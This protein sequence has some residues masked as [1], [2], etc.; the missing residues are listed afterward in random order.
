MPRPWRL[1]WRRGRGAAAARRLPSRRRAAPGVLAQLSPDAFATATAAKIEGALHLDRLTRA[2]PLEH[3]V[4]F[5][6]AAALLGLP[7]QGA[8]AAAN[9]A[10]DALARRRRAAGLPALSIGWGRWSEVGMVASDAVRLEAAGHGAIVPDAGLAL[11]ERI[12]D[13]PA[14]QAVLPADWPRLLAGLPRRPT[15]LAELERPAPQPV[16]QPAPPAPAVPAGPAPGGMMGYLVA[17]LQRITGAAMP[18]PAT[19]TLLELGL[20]S[21]TSINLRNR[22]AREVGVNLP[23]GTLM[24]ATLRQ[25]AA[26]LEARADLAGR[27]RMDAGPVPAEAGDAPMEEDILL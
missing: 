4:L 17:E 23:L 3:F 18:P 5:S 26:E 7:G 15:L 1:C 16:F 11:L 21:L 13:G 2:A 6:S 24:D 14:H 12:S 27:I 19:S 20:D 22:I 8:Y 9:A 10:L 25:L